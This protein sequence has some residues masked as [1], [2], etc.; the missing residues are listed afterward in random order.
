MHAT[1]QTFQ[2]LLS[3]LLEKV[4]D[5]CPECGS[6][7]YVWQQKNKDGT[8]RCAPTCWS[9][10]YK[11]LRSHST[12]FSREFYGTYTKIFSSRVLNC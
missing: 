11:M 2:I 7:Q 1:D 8:E 12:T 3:Q 5:R 6:E 4:E 10:G 9:C